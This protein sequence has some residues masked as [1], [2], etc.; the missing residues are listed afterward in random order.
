MP[1]KHGPS[2]RNADKL[3]SLDIS[4]ELVAASLSDTPLIARLRFVS[5]LLLSGGG[6]VGNLN[7]DPV[8]V[9]AVEVLSGAIELLET[10]PRAAELTSPPVPRPRKTKSPSPKT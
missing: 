4:V 2:S 9:A 5:N 6:Y 8:Q 3:A 1:N 7:C 10:H